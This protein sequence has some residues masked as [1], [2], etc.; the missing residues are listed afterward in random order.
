MLFSNEI[1]ALKEIEESLFPFETHSLG[2]EVTWE[3][4]ST[5]NMVRGSNG[6]FSVIIKTRVLPH[7]LG[8]IVKI[9]FHFHTGLLSFIV[10]STYFYNPNHRSP[11]LYLWIPNFEIPFPV[12]IPFFSKHAERQTPLLFNLRLIELKAT[13]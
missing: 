7:T 3:W 5:S 4:V 1:V 2:E 8:K 12:L 9:T 10:I 13:T 11:W 6:Y